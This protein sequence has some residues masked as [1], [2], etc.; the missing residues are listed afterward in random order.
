MVRNLEHSH[1]SS[2][3][4]NDIKALHIHINAVTKLCH[5]DVDVDI[6]LWVRIGMR[7]VFCF[8]LFCF[9]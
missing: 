6:V 8:F 3:R 7:A 9:F 2:Y 4:K 1:Y 5:T